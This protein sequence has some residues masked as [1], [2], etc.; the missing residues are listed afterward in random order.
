MMYKKTYLS[1]LF[2]AGTF[3]AAAQGG[4]NL[5]PA[6]K[7][8]VD[9]KDS[10][11]LQQELQKLVSS[12]KEEDL[13]LASSY[14]AYK[15]NGPKRD[16]VNKIAL[17]KFPSGV[18]ALGNA[19]GTIYD[20]QDGPANEKNY[21]TLIKQ[22]GNIPS[23]KG[24]IRFEHA[25]FFV[26]SS[27]ANE[28]PAKVIAW[29]DK[30]QDTV[31]RTRAYSYGARE[32][33]AAGN[34]VPAEMLIKRSLADLERRG[35]TNTPE[36]KEYQ[37]AVAAYLLANKKYE[38]GYRY[39]VQVY[40]SADKRDKA[41]A[42]TYLSLLVGSERY[43]EALP[44]ME[45]AMRTG[46]AS[47][48]MKER[49]QK[50]FTAV[51]GKSVDYKAYYSG[52]MEDFRNHIHKE[53]MAKMEKT[54]GYNF[55]VKTLDGKTVTLESLKGKVVVL[56]FWATW[57]GPCKAS[58]PKM[59]M[60]VDK[61]K[62][63]PEVAFLFIHTWETA[64]DPVKDAGNYI[65]DHKYTFHVGM[66]LKDANKKNDA[67]VGYGLKG[68]PAKFVIDKNGNIRF[69]STGNSAGGEDAF[70]A[71]MGVMIEAAKKG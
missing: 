1:L 67:A 18:T 6:L 13:M 41:F 20:E 21:E 69:R 4:R 25:K 42:V 52:L 2:A 48:L 53:V 49:L 15:M 7:A 3:V 31:Y 27:F 26:A 47:P 58:F 44:G 35:Q 24:H 19:V 8:L 43:A 59:Q 22:F 38:E 51:H 60:A 37:K 28:N 36:Y 32:L 68:I 62:K 64:A 16:A 70:L 5:P 54:P 33:A 45:E 14:Y 10:V 50:A 11:V 56:D 63:D 12:D 61:Y 23:L 39:A 34:H 57:C 66:D 17:E 30:I 29:I 55:S 65:R 71:E 9:Q 46:T 40:D